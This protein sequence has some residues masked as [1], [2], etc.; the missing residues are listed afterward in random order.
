MLFQKTSEFDNITNE[1]F[2]RVYSL[3]QQNLSVDMPDQKALLSLNSNQPDTLCKE[4]QS[5]PIK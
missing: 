4:Y 5:I 2:K 1:T 3:S